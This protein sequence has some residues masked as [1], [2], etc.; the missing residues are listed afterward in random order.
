MRIIGN[1]GTGFWFPKLVSFMN[2]RDNHHYFCFYCYYYYFILNL[3]VS[4]NLPMINPAGIGNLHYEFLHDRSIQYG[5]VDS[6]ARP[7]HGTSIEKWFVVFGRCLLGQT[8]GRALEFVGQL[9]KIQRHTRADGHSGV[10]AGR[11][12]RFLVVVNSIRRSWNFGIRPSIAKR[13]VRL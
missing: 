1:T 5:S 6:D 4:R 10:L 8:L 7:K 11:A 9:E 3:Y 12:R 13:C 2:N